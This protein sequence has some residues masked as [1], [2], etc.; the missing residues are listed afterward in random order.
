MNWSMF[1]DLIFF[2]L[3]RYSHNLTGTLQLHIFSPG[4]LPLCHPLPLMMLL[5]RNRS[6]NWS[7]L[8]SFFRSMI[9]KLWSFLFSMIPFFNS[10]YSY[11]QLVINHYH[12]WQKNA[13][14]FYATHFLHPSALRCLTSMTGCSSEWRTT[15]ADRRPGLSMWVNSFSIFLS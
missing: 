3:N 10:S 11:H 8:K 12:S 6:L 1:S 9:H 7:H 4:T 15:E 5:S 14:S 13:N 2:K